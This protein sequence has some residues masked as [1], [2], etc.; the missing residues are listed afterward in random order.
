LEQLQ[1]AEQEWLFAPLL[2]GH[3][4]RGTREGKPNTNEVL[5]VSATNQDIAGFHQLDQRLLHPTRAGRPR[6]PTS[7]IGQRG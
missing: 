2:T 3:H 5:T 7:P 1:P 4:H 6:P